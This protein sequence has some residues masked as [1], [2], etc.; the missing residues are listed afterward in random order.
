[1]LHSVTPHPP[2]DLHPRGGDTALDRITSWTWKTAYFLYILASLELGI[3]LIYLP[4]RQYWDNNYLLYL[5]PQFRPLISSAYF[6]GFVL[7]LG[8]VNILIGI[9]EIANIRHNWKVRHHSG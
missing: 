7:G 8:I 4:F 3:F 9:H 1:M 5:Y 6:K 2:A